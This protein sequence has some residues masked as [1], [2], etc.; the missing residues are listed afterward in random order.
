MDKVPLDIFPLTQDVLLD[1]LKFHQVKI[2]D[3]ISDSLKAFLACLQRPKR[4]SSSKFFLDLKW[5]KI[6][7]QKT[8]SSNEL[9]DIVKKAQ[10]I[11]ALETKFQGISTLL[12]EFLELRESLDDSNP[13]K[14]FLDKIWNV[15]LV[16]DYLDVSILSNV[17][18]TAK[19]IEEKYKA[20]QNAP[21]KKSETL[22]N[23]NSVLANGTNYLRKIGFL[24]KNF[25][26]LT[27]ILALIP[28]KAL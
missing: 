3:D 14:G 16:A 9:S 21:E 11:E 27:K 6:L 22:S 1:E 19:I 23:L 8:L 7:D 2:E 10:S 24:L 4:D 12:N 18:H 5:K 28:L 13:A 15:I 17:V 26:N 20:G 25:S